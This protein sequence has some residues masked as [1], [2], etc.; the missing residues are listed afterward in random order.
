MAGAAIIWG[1]TPLFARWSGAAPLVTVFWRV[2]FAS[3]ALL[4]YVL[5]TGQLRLLLRLSRRTVWALLLLG[6]LLAAGWATLFTAFTWT[7]VAT[8]ILLNYIGPLFVAVFTPLATGAP[9]DRRIV[10]P[11]V[12]A[13]VGTAIIVG[14]QA[15]DA[16][17]SRNLLGISMAVVSA[18][19][20]ALTVLINKRVLAGVPPG[21]AAFVQ[22]VTAAV[23]LLPAVFFFPGP[24]GA[25]GWGAVA[26]LGVVHT[27]LA[28][29]L[30][31]QGLR[32]VRTDHVAVLSYIEPLA[33]VVL[34]ALFLAEPLTWYTGLGGAAVLAGGIMVARMGV[35]PGPESP[36]LP[37]PLN[38]PLSG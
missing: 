19:I 6:V 14:P 29:L 5:A 22:Q 11:L 1:S 13:V 18:G 27:G 36:S 38:G 7:T 34:A 12:M 17:G 2:T 35:V 9:P 37:P 25:A 33:A 8:A 30:F 4:V 26:M 24:G 20:Y 23:V 32:L 21:L 3:V 28:M 16:G 15:L 31:Y 10:F